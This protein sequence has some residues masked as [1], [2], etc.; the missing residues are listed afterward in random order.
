MDG[1]EYS[2]MDITYDW[3]FTVTSTI[4][5]GQNFV[6]SLSDK[7]LEVASVS[8]PAMHVDVS[9]D[10]RNIHFLRVVDGQV[11]FSAK[12]PDE[13]T[14]IYSLRFQVQRL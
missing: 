6:V 11:F 8:Q 13:S 10:L 2:R 5:S 12:R 7:L 3:A 9:Q 14:S 1:S 4:V